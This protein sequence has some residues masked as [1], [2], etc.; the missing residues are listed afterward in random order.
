MLLFN[1]S[2]IRTY[3]QKQLTKLMQ[4]WPF[5]KIIKVFHYKAGG[6]NSYLVPDS[7]PKLSVANLAANSFLL[8]AWRSQ[9]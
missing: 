7:A 9:G 6:V 4:L 2:R 8:C 5:D 1:I 3:F